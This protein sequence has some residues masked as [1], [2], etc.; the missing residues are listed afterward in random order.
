MKRRRRIMIYKQAESLWHVI[1]DVDK[2]STSTASLR[3]SD[4]QNGVRLEFRGFDIMQYNERT[5]Q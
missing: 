5:V 2:K 4:V 3:E 1:S